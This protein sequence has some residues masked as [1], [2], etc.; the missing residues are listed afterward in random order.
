MGRVPGCRVAVALVIADLRLATWFAG[1][2]K[3][4][5]RIGRVAIAWS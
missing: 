3:S 4:Y 1:D 5:G 2:A